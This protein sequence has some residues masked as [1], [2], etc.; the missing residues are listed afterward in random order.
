MLMIQIEQCSALPNN[1]HREIRLCMHPVN[2]TKE[3]LDIFDQIKGCAKNMVLNF[4]FAHVS[5]F[6]HWII[7]ILV[8]T[9]YNIP[10]NMW[11]RHKNFKD[12]CTEAEI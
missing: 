11:G 1:G 6:V 5:A 2:S 10:P 7:K 12:Q 8:C 3:N 9:P 4:W